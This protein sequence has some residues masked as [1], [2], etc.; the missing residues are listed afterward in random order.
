MEQQNGTD[1]TVSRDEGI[2]EGELSAWL[3]EKMA[4]RRPDILQNQTVKGRLRLL[5]QEWPSEHDIAGTISLP[6]RKD[7]VD[8]IV[9]IF[10]L[11]PCFLYDFASRKGIPLRTKHSTAEGATSKSSQPLQAS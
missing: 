4:F 6:M 2:K 8:E 3:E 1:R 11:P 7:A 9:R 5:Y 10:K